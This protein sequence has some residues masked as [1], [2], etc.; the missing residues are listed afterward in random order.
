[1]FRHGLR[2]LRPRFRQ[3]KWQSNWQSNWQ[4]SY[5]RLALGGTGILLTAGLGF[6]ASKSHCEQIDSLEV[7]LTKA[8]IKEI[9]D[10]YDFSRTCGNALAAVALGGLVVSSVASF[11]N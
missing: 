3:S 1:M 8:Q 11:K 5:V 9:I 6:G 7:K 2:L 10:A 4:S